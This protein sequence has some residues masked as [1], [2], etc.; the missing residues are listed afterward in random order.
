MCVPGCFIVTMF[1]LRIFEIGFLPVYMSGKTEDNESW[2]Q[3]GAKEQ[4]K[5]KYDLIY[6][7]VFPLKKSAK[8]GRNKYQIKN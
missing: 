6:T 2:L 7:L 4:L 3:S 8:R 5:T 1:L